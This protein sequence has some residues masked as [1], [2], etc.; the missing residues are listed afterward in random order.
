MLRKAVIVSVLVS[1]AWSA[2]GRAQQL[3]PPDTPQNPLA[4][5]R[6]DAN[7]VE[8]DA[9]VTDGRGNPVT[10][11]S[12]DDFEIYEDGKRQAP[13]VFAL[14][15]LPLP[16]PA[17]IARA[18]AVEPDVR[19]TRHTFDGRLYV[20]VL[21]D[22]HTTLTRTPVVRN[23]A[24]RFIEQYAGPDDLVAVVP[25][26]GRMDG[27]QELTSNHRLL[28][29]AVDRFMGHKLQSAASEKLAVHLLDSTQ[30]T[31]SDSS[32][33]SSANRDP[34]ADPD[35]AERAM[36]ARRL[37]DL[38]TNLAGWMTDIQGRRK[39]MVLFSEGIDYDIYDVFNNRSAGTL[40]DRPAGG[41]AP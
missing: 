4:T 27:A 39:A 16:S 15:N 30:S 14:V 25:T 20:L 6:A 40:M 18:A 38:V 12:R 2:G 19:T 8:I 37:F 28:L 29:Q 7:F 23:A 21:D 36:N 5:F 13:S 24:K 26:S 31:S 11:L 17:A 3:P 22:L 35:E 1:A 10:N 9:V 32:T 33:S 41:I 34:I